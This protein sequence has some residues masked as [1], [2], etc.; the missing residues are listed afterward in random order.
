MPILS[1][2]QIVLAGTSGHTLALGSAHLA[3]T[4]APDT[5]GHS[6]LSGH[7]DIHFRFVRDLTPGMEMRLR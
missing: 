4:A 7:R 6:S 3:G 1:V 2:D 5:A